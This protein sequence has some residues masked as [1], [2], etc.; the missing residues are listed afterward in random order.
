MGRIQVNIGLNDADSLGSINISNSMTLDVGNVVQTGSFTLS[1]GEAFMPITKTTDSYEDQWN[2]KGYF[3]Y[4]KN[5]SSNSSAHLSILVTAECNESGGTPG[6]TTVQRLYAGEFTWMNAASN[7]ASGV[8]NPRAIRVEN[9]S[10]E[11]IVLDYA[12]FNREKI[13]GPK[14]EGGVIKPSGTPSGNVPPMY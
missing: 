10:G 11:E 7:I 4:I 3:M 8:T 6:Y 12:Y 5:T 14:K 13:G 9:N 2:E 1:S